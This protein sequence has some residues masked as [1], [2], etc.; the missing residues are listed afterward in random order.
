MLKAGDHTY[1]AK[2][3]TQWEGGIHLKG[4][5]EAWKKWVDGLPNGTVITDEMLN[6]G[7]MDIY[8]NPDFSIYLA[9]GNRAMMSYQEWR[10]GYRV[11]ESAAKAEISSSIGRG[12]VRCGNAV[13]FAFQVGGTISDL[14]Q[15]VREANNSNPYVGYDSEGDL[16]SI[17]KNKVRDWGLFGYNH[18]KITGYFVVS[19]TGPHRGQ[20][21]EIPQEVFDEVE[22]QLKELGQTLHGPLS[23]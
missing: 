19:M 11:V 2:V 15:M 5:N 8:S 17:G 20:G 13:I 7:I 16:F 4:F 12:A 9:K 10:A 23:L 6:A 21:F 14:N 18:Y 3:G 1:K 22:K